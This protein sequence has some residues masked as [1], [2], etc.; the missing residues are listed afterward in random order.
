[1][2]D[3]TFDLESGIFASGYRVRQ[4]LVVRFFAFNADGSY[5]GG[6]TARLI[7]TPQKINF[8]FDNFRDIASLYISSYSPYDVQGFFPV[9]MDDIRVHWNAPAPRTNVRPGSP[10][11]FHGVHPHIAHALIFAASIHFEEQSGADD[12][13]QPD[14][15]HGEFL[16]LAGAFGHADPGGGLTGQFSLPHTDWHG[17]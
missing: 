1:M 17:G 7:Q 16:S 13:V 11:L 15:H 14:Y 12:T 10:A 3:K 4:P 2:Q 5:H 6:L 8:T 9:A